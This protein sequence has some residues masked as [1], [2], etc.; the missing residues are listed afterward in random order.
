MFLTL[1]SPLG[2]KTLR[3]LWCS[4]E[5]KPNVSI[6]PDREPT[7]V[8]NELAWKIGYTYKDLKKGDPIYIKRDQYDQLKKLS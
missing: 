8:L 4:V 1:T 2:G 3:S 6:D 5:N 7:L